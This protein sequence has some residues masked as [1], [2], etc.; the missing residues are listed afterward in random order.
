LD[1]KTGE[2]VWH[3]QTVH[4]PI[5][6]YDLPA[7]PVLIDITVDGKVIPA[8]AQITKQ[9]TTFVFDRRTGEPVWPIEE[10]AYPS[11][12][13]PDEITAPTQPV[14]TLPEP[15]FPSGVTFDDLNDLTPEI[16]REAQRIVSKYTIGPMFTPPTVYSDTNGGTL[17]SPSGSGGANWQGAVADP[18]TGIMYVSSA[19]TVGV[20]G[21]INDPDRSNMQFVSRSAEVEGPFGLPLF[22]PP[23]GRITAIDLNT[24][25]VKW[26]I[27]NGE[28][29]DY[30]TNHEKLAGI[31]IPKTGHEERAGLLVTKSLL[32]AGEGSGLYAMSG[33]GN[34]FRAH[35]KSTGNVVAEIDLGS[36]QTGVP[37]TYAINGKQYIVVAT[38]AP[39]RPG[40]LVAIALRE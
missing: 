34:K 22:K 37:M 40:E 12:N 11:S 9:G 6:D 38:G 18:E 32:F 5:W 25:K 14:P 7:A 2:R 15:F 39:N 30:V 27:A 20:L 35:D 21:M 10:V 4:H 33:G 29:P 24:G 13:V 26:T 28:T 3:F 8:V 16:Y 36:R 1:A 31:D 19:K 23:W 17:F